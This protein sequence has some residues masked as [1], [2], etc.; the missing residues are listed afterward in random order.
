MRTIAAVSL[1]LFASGLVLLPYAGAPGSTGGVS[2]TGSSP[3]AEFLAG[4]A[5]VAL[6]FALVAHGRGTSPDAPEGTQLGDQVAPLQE[7]EVV[8]GPPAVLVIGPAPVLLGLGRWAHTRLR[9]AGAL[10]LGVLS[11]VL[12]LVLVGV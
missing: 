7:T 9:R 11:L 12:V 5:L 6:G 8:K 3:L 1:T 2:L 10:G 4:L